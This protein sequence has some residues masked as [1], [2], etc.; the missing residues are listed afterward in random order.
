[1]TE[2]GAPAFKGFSFKK[3]KIN[4]FNRS[5]L[6]AKHEEEDNEEEGNKNS[7]NQN[8]N[9][10][11]ANEDLKKAQKQLQNDRKSQMV[12]QQA[13]EQDDEIFQYDEIHDKIS[14]T[15]LRE[16]MEEERKEA[17]YNNKAP[18]YIKG[19]MKTAAKRNLESERRYERRAVRE[20]KDEDHLFNDKEKFVTPAFKAKMLKLEQA[21]KEEAHMDAIDEMHDVTKQQDISGFH[22]HF[23]NDT[24]NPT[25]ILRK[26]T[27]SS[28]EQK[29]ENEVK[30]ENDQD[31]EPESEL[32]KNSEKSPTKIS[33]DEDENENDKKSDAEDHPRR[34]RHD[35]SSS[36]GSEAGSDV[37]SNFSGA[38][39]EVIGE[40]EDPQ[41]EDDPELQKL[42]SRF[43][44]PKSV[45]NLTSAASTI[46]GATNDL[47]GFAPAS[48]SYSK[49]STRS[50]V[51]AGGA[52]IETEVDYDWQLFKLRHIF[53]KRLSEDDVEAARRRYHQRNAMRDAK[54]GWSKVL[55]TWKE[56][57]K[58]KKF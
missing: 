12:V 56:R 53:R 18:K 6:F 54:G 8:F 32:E 14:S 38:S 37:G 51:T 44:I 7:K 41:P 10:K 9:R 1:M 49:I 57:K 46:G 26:M 52:G 58:I 4:T 24:Y 23:L 43:A 5:S 17:S 30:K 20:R 47:K 22:R 31:P 29:K 2:N 33:E 16:Q 13:L 48:T 3:R 55:A 27:G 25:N 42:K 36:E 39:N 28:A 21:E 35:S 45:P 40:F 19:L 15:K 50:K 11:I 34:Q